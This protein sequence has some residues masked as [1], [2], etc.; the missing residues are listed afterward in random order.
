VATAVQRRPDA[1]CRSGEPAPPLTI[2]TA[3]RRWARGSPARH[4]LAANGPSPTAGRHR[5]GAA[6]GPRPLERRADQRDAARAR[7][8]DLHG[9]GGR[10]RR[11]AAD[12]EQAAPAHR[13][14]K[15]GPAAGPFLLVKSSA[16]DDAETRLVPVLM[17]SGAWDDPTG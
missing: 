7:D 9:D 13:P 16:V 11:D 14:M 3:A 12:G 5:R 4:A 8:V 6:G 2:T 1:A 10:R 15:G 17:V